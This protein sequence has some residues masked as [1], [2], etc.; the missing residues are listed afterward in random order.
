MKVTVVV[1]T[2]KRP[3]FLKQ[4]LTSIQ[5]QT[6]ANWEVILFDDS[7]STEN[8]GI[9]TKFKEQN[10]TKRIIYITSATPYDMFKDSWN[11]SPKLSTGEV[12]VR[13]D[14]DDLLVENSLEYI[15]D[16]YLNNPL[17]DFTYG[18]ATFFQNDEL[19]RK[20]T[21]QTPL[22]PTKTRDIWEG[23]LNDHPF[24]HPWRFKSNHYDTPQ[25]YTSIIHCSKANEMCVYH[26]YTMRTSSLLKVAD[27]FEVTSN[28][29]DDLEAMGSMD[30][31]GL[32]H[33]SIKR[34]LS[35]IRIHDNGRV[36]DKKGNNG[37]TIWDNILRIRDSVEYH[38]TDGF[39]SN[40]YTNPIDG[41]TNDEL[42]MESKNIF[43]EYLY[44]I[45]H[46]SQTLG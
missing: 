39:Q 40:V 14:D 18:S 25:H 37:D 22:E 46:L 32:S 43:K 19:V 23:Y 21:T 31:M 9:Y 44:R 33:T 36:T 34:T 12:I 30:Y 45:K 11:I 28:F 7:G 26:T 13:L 17:L 3:E 20:S 8:L 24:K 2:F 6:Y 10:P 4:A 16:I 41:N 15:A 1:R 42:T 27:K 5:L 29:V 38:R 35:Y